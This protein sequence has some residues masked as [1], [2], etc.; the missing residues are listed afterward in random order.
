MMILLQSTQSA[1]YFSSLVL[2]MGLGFA[3][4][5][6]VGSVAW[7]NSKRPLGWED[8]EKPDVVP[9]INDF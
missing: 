4:A 8:K 3:I 6:L 2:V 5:T 9:D 7:Y 1:P